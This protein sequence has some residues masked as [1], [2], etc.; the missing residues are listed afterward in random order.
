MQDFRHFLDDQKITFNEADLANSL[1]WVKA[2]IKSELFISEFGQQ[3]G[4]QVH[5]ERDPEVL[6]ALELLP[7]AKE[8][9]ENARKIIA[10][11]NTA[12]PPTQ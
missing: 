5:A 10:D 12:H 9:A 7:K 1:D 11:R 2:N 4:L 8:L 3:E 6:K